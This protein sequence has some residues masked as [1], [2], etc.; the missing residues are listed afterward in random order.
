VNREKHKLKSLDDEKEEGDSGDI[1]GKKTGRN[2]WFFFVLAKIAKA[3][4]KRRKQTTVKKQNLGRPSKRKS[5]QK[6]T[7]RQKGVEPEMR[8]KDIGDKKDLRRKGR[9]AP[10]VEGGKKK[11]GNGGAQEKIAVT[12]RDGGKDRGR[13]K[14]QDNK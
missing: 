11:R 12:G 10:T 3:R 14:S 6:E 1:W 5:R 13:E 8:R 9:K 4:G 7:H 2:S